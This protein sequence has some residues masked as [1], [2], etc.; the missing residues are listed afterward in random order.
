MGT[1]KTSPGEWR[2]ES[3]L[4]PGQLMDSGRFA[5][6]S[7][8]TIVSCLVTEHRIHSTRLACLDSENL[9]PF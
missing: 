8:A 4:L 1:L 3:V 5:V 6:S 2:V 9:G 7:L